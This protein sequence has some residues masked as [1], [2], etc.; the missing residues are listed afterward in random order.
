[1]FRYLAVS[2]A[3]F[4][5]SL[6]SLRLISG[7]ESVFCIVVTPYR[8]ISRR[9]AGMSRSQTVSIS[10]SFRRCLRRVIPAPCFCAATHARRVLFQ[11][12]EMVSIHSVAEGYVALRPSFYFRVALL[13]SR[14]STLRFPPLRRICMPPLCRHALLIGA[15]NTARRRDVSELQHHTTTYYSSLDGPVTWNATP[16]YVSALPCIVYRVLRCHTEF[17]SLHKQVSYIFIY[18]N[19]PTCCYI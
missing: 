7:R 1:M 14:P 5:I 10:D 2:F 6:I 12:A 18:K 13:I 16:S 4:I 17:S 15:E 19:M 3:I 11:T 9:H 8:R